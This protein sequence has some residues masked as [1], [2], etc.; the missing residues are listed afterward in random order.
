MFW[1][2]KQKQI[3]RKTKQTTQKTKNN[4]KPISGRLGKRAQLSRATV[5]SPILFF[6][7]FLIFLHFLK[8]F[9]VSCCACSEKLQAGHPRQPQ[10]MAAGPA[11]LVCKILL[12]WLCGF[13]Y[14]FSN[15]FVSVQPHMHFSKSTKTQPPIITVK[16]LNCNHT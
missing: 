6:L 4:Q 16:P 13:R 2:Q 11:C 12:F 7:I 8:V 9:L 5:V 3:L 15:C 10:G 1:L 14:I